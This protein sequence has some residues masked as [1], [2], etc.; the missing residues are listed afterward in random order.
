MTTAPFAIGGHIYRSNGTTP[1]GAVTVTLKSG[2][3]GITLKSVYTL[4][5][6]AF[7]FGAVKP[8]TYWLSV[9]KRGYTFP[10]PTTPGNPAVVVGPGKSG[11]AIKA[12][13]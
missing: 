12:N 10:A 4:D 5:D 2:T 3:T 11:I 9:S 1:L 6:G 8:D 13:P 7:S